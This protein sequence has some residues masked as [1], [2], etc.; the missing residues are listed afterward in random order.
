MASGKPVPMSQPQYKGQVVNDPCYKERE[1][2]GRPAVQETAA[3]GSVLQR[4]LLFSGC[5]GRHL[6][7]FPVNFL[8]YTKVCNEST[9]VEGTGS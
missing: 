4:T 3:L 1:K 8:T 9:A 2:A 5:G 7:S 6:L